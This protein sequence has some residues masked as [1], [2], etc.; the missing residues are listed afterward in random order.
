MFIQYLNKN[1]KARHNVYPEYSFFPAILDSCPP[2]S[3]DGIRIRR[4]IHEFQLL[5]V[6]ILLLKQ[7][8]SVIEGQ[9]LTA[10][11]LTTI[12]G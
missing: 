11:R 4:E 5:D 12:L 6:L 2:G 7:D 3:S 10:A 1:I 8:Y 9:W